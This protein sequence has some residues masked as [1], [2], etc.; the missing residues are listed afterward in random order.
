MRRFPADLPAAHRQAWLERAEREARRA[1]QLE[2][3][4]RVLGYT[5]STWRLSD[6]QIADGIAR[7]VQTIGHPRCLFIRGVQPLAGLS[8]ANEK[9]RAAYVAAGWPFDT[10]AS[11]Y[12][13]AR[14]QSSCGIM[15][16]VGWRYAGVVDPDGVLY[17][18]YAKRVNH[19]GTW[20]AVSRELFLAQHYGCWVDAV[21]WREG[22]ALPREADAMIIGCSACGPS[23][24]RGG[25]F[26]G[27]HEFPICL[28]GEDGLMHS[29]DGGQPGVAYRTRC[30]VQ[31]WTG[32]DSQGRT[33]EL[34][35]G[36]VDKHGACAIGADGRPL[37]GRRVMG[38]TDVAGLQLQANGNDCGP[39]AAGQGLFGIA[40]A[41]EALEIAGYVAGAA[42]AAEVLFG[43]FGVLGPG[44]LSKYVRR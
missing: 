29:I 19:G 24:G 6:A 7:V 21:H 34:W 30:L 36:A 10:E 18:P 38:W 8:Y 32:S 23:W 5:G 9:T 27:E 35:C 22:M 17:M 16:E 14:D 15:T 26:F 37:S 4:P 39:G 28:W 13:Q 33:G 43:V 31:V 12:A 41:D 1:H 44:L 25:G 20:Y 2:P 3:A 11:A 42:V 40:G